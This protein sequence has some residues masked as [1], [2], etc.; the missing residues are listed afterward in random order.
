MPAP[1]A[2]NLLICIVAQA[3][4]PAARRLPAQA[5]VGSGRI[6]VCNPG[7]QDDL[8]LCNLTFRS[9]K[10]QLLPQGQIPLAAHGE[11]GT[12]KGTKATWRSES[13]II[14]AKRQGQEQRTTF[15]RT[16]V[17]ILCS[18]FYH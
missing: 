2:C 8:A 13:T 6:E 11:A 9:G 4:S 14:A 5:H 7:V 3:V 1:F 12:R 16:R 15:L 10:R 17:L 18:Q